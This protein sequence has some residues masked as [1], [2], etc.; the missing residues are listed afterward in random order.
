[1]NPEPKLVLAVE[2]RVIAFPGVAEILE[3]PAW[4]RPIVMKAYNEFAKTP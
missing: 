3:T 2:E 4:A 1:M